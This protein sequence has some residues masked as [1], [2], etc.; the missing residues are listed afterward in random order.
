MTLDGK[1]RI[2]GRSGQET[3]H[4]LYQ[5]PENV[6]I[7]DTKKDQHAGRYGCANDASDSTKCPK[8]GAD[9]CSCGS[10]HDGRDDHNAVYFSM[11]LKLG[12]RGW[13]KVGQEDKRRWSFT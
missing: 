6:R 9:R 3:S 7:R 2:F 5:L 4:L 1:L 8:F 10:D 13:R 11:C 12:N